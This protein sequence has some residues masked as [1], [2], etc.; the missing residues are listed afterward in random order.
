MLL[1]GFVH[2]TLLKLYKLALILGTVIAI[3]SVHPR[4]LAFNYMYTHDYTVTT[5]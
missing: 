5:M 4:Y 2:Y 3:L 1:Y